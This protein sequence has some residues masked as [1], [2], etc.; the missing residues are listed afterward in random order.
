MPVPE[1]LVAMYYRALETGDMNAL[2]NLMVPESYLMTLEAFGLKRSFTDPEFK[3][4]LQRIETDGAARF[5]VE[6]IIARMLRRERKSPQIA[7]LR[8]EPLGQDR[9]AVIYTEDDI[10]KKL[11]FSKQGTA[12]W[13]L[14]YYA[15]R[16]RDGGAD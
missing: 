12:G 8:R 6:C 9:C 4:L 14:D 16:R 3:A 7:H 5:E 10:P 13:R 2:R 1:A 11:S 15:G